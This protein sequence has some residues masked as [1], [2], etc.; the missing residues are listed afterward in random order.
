MNLRPSPEDEAFRL[1]V[2]AWLADNLAGELTA[3][4]GRGFPGP[5]D[6][7][8]DLGLRRAW[9]RRL[10]EAGWIGL[11]WPR[12]EG[13]RGASLT[14]QVIFNEEYAA[15]DAPARLSMIGEGLVAPTLIKYGTPA[16]RRRFLPPIARGEELWCQGY[17]EPGAGSD[18]AAVQTRAELRGGEW[19]IT[20]QKVW[21]SLAHVADWCFALCRTDPAAPRHR[22]LSYLLVPMRQPGVVVRPIVQLTGT[23][24]FCEVFFDGARSAAEHLVGEAGG[25]WRVAMGTLAFERGT[26]TLGQQIAFGRE[27]DLVLGVARRSGAARDPLLRQRLVRAY[28][29]LRILRFCALRVLG[30]LEDGGEPGPEASIIKLGWSTWHRELG[31]L[32][33]DVLGAAAEIAASPDAAEE[34]ERTRARLQRLFLFSRAD[35]IYAGSSEIQRN[36]IAERALHLP[37]DPDKT[38]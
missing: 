28:S 32:A 35:T 26:A 21:T 11:G 4:R 25:G 20:G 5:G 3:L 24:E 9:E 19:V 18:L 22:G 8:E 16:Q 7:D 33:M 29:G 31:E 27:L 2:R 38:R 17:S 30:R 34:E 36:I 37:G 10:G 23:A 12:A 1:Q 6:G 13:G 14:E 15:A